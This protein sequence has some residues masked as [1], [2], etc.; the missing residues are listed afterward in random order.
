[1]GAHFFSEIIYTVATL[2]MKQSRPIVLHANTSWYVKRFYSE[3]VDSLVNDGQTVVIVVPDGEYSFE[4]CG[5]NVH[6]LPMQRSGVN[7]V[8]E[9]LYYYRFL[10]LLSSIRPKAVLNFTVKPNIYGG[11]AAARLGLPAINTVSGIGSSLIGRGPVFHVVRYLYA[12]ASRHSV[13]VFLNSTDKKL[14]EE[15]GIRAKHV[16]LAP[17]AGIDLNEYRRTSAV[18]NNNTFLYLGRL[19]RDKGIGEYLEAARRLNASGSRFLVGGEVDPG[20]RSS[21]SKDEISALDK[22]GVVEHLGFVDDVR[23][24]LED[25]DCLVLPS[26]AEGLSRVMLEAAA[27]EVGLIASDVPGCRELVAPGAGT[28]VFAT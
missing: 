25:V 2:Q 10:R 22:A 5:V 4:Q 1:M 19:I 20:N 11:I 16:A 26:Y 8:F 13:N 3:F 21:I 12:L 28:L 15:M 23:G 24:L 6:I 27:M 17:G 9:C 7:P 18:V 14:F